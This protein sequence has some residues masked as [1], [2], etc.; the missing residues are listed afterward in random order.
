MIDE[1]MIAEH[2]KDKLVYETYFK[3][4][5]IREQNFDSATPRQRFSSQS[6]QMIDEFKEFI[7]ELGSQANEFNNI[8]SQFFGR[9]DIMIRVKKQLI[10]LFFTK[11]IP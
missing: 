7:T 10:K 3:L 1:A 9:D 5:L 11:K 4:G 8:V 6:S 2:E